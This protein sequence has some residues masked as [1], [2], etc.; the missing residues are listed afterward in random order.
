MQVNSVARPEQFLQ[1]IKIPFQS[2]FKRYFNT[3]SLIV[4]I[5]FSLPIYLSLM[6]DSFWVK[7]L[8]STVAI[9]AL[10]LFLNIKHSFFQTGFFIGIFWF[11]WVGLS[12]RYYGLSYIIPLVVLF[13]GIGYGLVF[14]VINRL[15][16]L[17]KKEI[18][19]IPLSTYL[20]GAFLIFGFDYL[21]PFTFDWLKPE[22]LIANSFFA[23]LKTTLALLVISALL[24]KPKRPLFIIPL[25]LA[26]FIPAPKTPL[27]PLKIKLITT[28]VPQD[29]KWEKSYIPIE[30]QNNFRHIQKAIKENYDAVVLPESAFPLFLNIHKD[31]MQKLKLLSY[32]IT[33][34]TGALHLKNKKF[35]NSTYIFENGKVTILDKHV[36]V[37]FGEY[38]PLPFFQKEINEIF[39]AGASDYA[40][41]KNFGI[42]SIKGIKFI[43]AICYEATL[44]ELYKLP[45]KY[46]IALSNDAWFTPS[47]QPVLQKLLIMVYAKQ[48]KKVVF[49][50]INGFKSYVIQ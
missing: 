7:L 46:V 5:L 27:P 14:W 48:Y 11:W 16:S 4:A 44:K 38:I 22:V 41:S 34:V 36:L 18:F 26:L 10:Y 49:H 33:I 40:T 50:S 31:L 9:I 12:F 45:P 37:P 17:I 28:Y 21:R 3:N 42:F 15:F 30:I 23:P 43:N 24:F 8:N 2:F 32:R 47:I 19:N 25:F 20:W 6:G 13:L 1:R 39:F 29:K 35:Y